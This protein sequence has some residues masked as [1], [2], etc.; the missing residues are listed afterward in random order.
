MTSDTPDKK[1]K[2]TG[3]L[4]MI[5]LVFLFSVSLGTILSDGLSQQQS[6]E[7]EEEAEALAVANQS[8][9]YPLDVKIK[10]AKSINSD[11]L[12]IETSAGQTDRL[13]QESQTIRYT[14]NEIEIGDRI[15]VYAV[16]EKSGSPNV[17]TQILTY[18]VE[19]P[20]LS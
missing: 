5:V 15:T 16:N 17:E 7:S 1:Q 12:R 10:Y 19:E 14:G 3:I 6:V 20:F 13:E 18:T 8:W 4:L 9:T 2:T 11:H